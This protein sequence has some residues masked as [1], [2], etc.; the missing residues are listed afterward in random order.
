M[1]AAVD[2]IGRVFDD[3]DMGLVIIVV[4]SMATGDFWRDNFQA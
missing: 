4:V 2:V 1:K 3:N